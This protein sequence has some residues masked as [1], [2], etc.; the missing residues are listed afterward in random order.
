L[1]YLKLIPDFKK[2][3]VQDIVVPFDESFRGVAIEVLTKLRMGK[4]TADIIL[5]MKEG[6]NKR[7]NLN[8]AY[9]YADR[10]G[11]SRVILIAPDEWKDKKVRV[12]FL[13]ESSGKD[14]TNSNEITVSLEDLL[15]I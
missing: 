9:S 3:N 8:Q 11:A 10:I 7:I 1:S 12:K 6:N 15:K 13:K 14:D 5:G 4:R 2:R